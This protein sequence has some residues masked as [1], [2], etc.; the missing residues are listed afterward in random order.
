MPQTTAIDLLKLTTLMALLAAMGLVF[1]SSFPFNPH[2]QKKA[3]VPGTTARN[4]KPSP[5]LPGT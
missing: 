1:L 3:S 5:P 4:F 2:K